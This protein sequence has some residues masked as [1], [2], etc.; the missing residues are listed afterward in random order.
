MPRG[1]EVRVL[2]RATVTSTSLDTFT[3][4]RIQQ[5]T[6]GRPVSA[7]EHSYVIGVPGAIRALRVA[8]FRGH[9]KVTFSQDPD[10]LFGWEGVSV[11]LR[12]DVDSSMIYVAPNHEIRARSCCDKTALAT[13]LAGMGREVPRT[14]PQLQHQRSNRPRFVA[15]VACSRRRR[16]Y[17]DQDDPCIAK[18]GF[19][20]HRNRCPDGYRPALALG[21]PDR[22]PCRH[23]RRLL[24][25]PS[26]GKR[27][28]G[29]LHRCC[30]TARSAEAKV[31]VGFTGSRHGMTPPQQM[32]LAALW[33]QPPFCDVLQVHHGDC[34]KT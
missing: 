24:A 9:P 1:R 12:I 14:R 3:A 29:V 16:R 5:E 30:S 22:V 2:P 13:I 6:L 23:D 26:S 25:R 18:L 11:R 10:E 21:N 27:Q 15:R 28:S 32:A 20:D 4:L 33:E 7:R 8:L 19:V 31:I 17:E 34:V